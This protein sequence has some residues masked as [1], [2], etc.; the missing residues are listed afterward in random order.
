MI[1]W[2]SLGLL[3]IIIFGKSFNIDFKSPNFFL[4]IILLGPI[5]W[6]FVILELIIK[7]IFYLFPEE[8]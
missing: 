4:L 6:I 5:A 7:S 3:Y 8:Y 2:L 1:I